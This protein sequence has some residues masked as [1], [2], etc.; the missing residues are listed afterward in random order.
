MLIKERKKNFLSNLNNKIMMIATIDSKKVYKKI[1]EN[2]S[3]AYKV[4]EEKTNELEEKENFFVDEIIITEPSS[5]VI[6]RFFA[7]KIDGLCVIMI[8]C[9]NSSILKNYIESLTLILNKESNNNE[10]SNF[11]L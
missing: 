11:K 8:V 7:R 6:I 5:K 1:V 9:D 3:E 4:L 10:L 2:K